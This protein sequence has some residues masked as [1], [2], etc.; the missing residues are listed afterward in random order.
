MNGKASVKTI[1]TY[2][3]MSDAVLC[4]MLF[5]YLTCGQGHAI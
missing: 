4:F 2:K 3:G 1:E 5:L